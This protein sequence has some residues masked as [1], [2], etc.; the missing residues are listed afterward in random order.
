[1]IG[2]TKYRIT[3]DTAESNIG[4]VR[5]VKVD[6]LLSELRKTILNAIETKREIWDLQDT[7]IYIS[8]FPHCKN[9]YRR[10]LSKI[11]DAEQFSF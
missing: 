9:P 3:S 1:M 11:R 6:S 7:C 10:I 5:V 4:D 2:H 8:D